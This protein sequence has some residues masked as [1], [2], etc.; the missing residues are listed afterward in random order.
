[1]STHTHTTK[2]IESLSFLVASSFWFLKF[3]LVLGLYHFSCS[4]TETLTGTWNGAIGSLRDYWRRWK[5][6]YSLLYTE[7]LKDP[8]ITI[9]IYFY[10][11]TK[12][13][14]KLSGDH[15]PDVPWLFILYS[16]VTV[17]HIK[18][19]SSQDWQRELNQQYFGSSLFPSPQ[20]PQKKK[21]SVSH[22]TVVSLFRAKTAS[23]LRSCPTENKISVKSLNGWN[24][25]KDT[26]LNFVLINLV[27][28]AVKTFKSNYFPSPIP[29]AF[30]QMPTKSFRLRIT[31]IK[32]SYPKT[33]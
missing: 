27:E 33:E 15:P 6:P 25:R 11:I 3:L 31:N 26:S 8:H 13:L 16:S 5:D 32:I 21:L 1:M 12:N 20:F 28:S 19:N 24:A 14:K 9:K 30:S 2:R 18:Q 23:S 17:M 22:W 4:S 10:K 7:S 29:T